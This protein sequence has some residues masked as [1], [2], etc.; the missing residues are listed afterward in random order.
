MTIKDPARVAALFDIIEK[1]AKGH[2]GFVNIGSEASAELREINEHIRKTHEKEKHQPITPAPV[3]EN[4]ASKPTEAAVDAKTP[5]PPV[6]P[7]PQPVRNTVDGM[8]GP[9][10]PQDEDEPLEVPPRAF[11]SGEQPDLPSINR[12]T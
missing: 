7:P 8:P 11:P 10:E 5:V 2:P 6:S 12:R 4:D 3:G 1:Q 9:A